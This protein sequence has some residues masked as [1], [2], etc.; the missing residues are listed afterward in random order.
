MKPLG[1]NEKMIEIEV[2]KGGETSGSSAAAS[3]AVSQ[4]RPTPPRTAVSANRKPSAVPSTPTAVARITLL[5]KAAWWLVSVMLDSNGS[6]VKPPSST[7]A[8]SSRC[9]IGNSTNNSS[10]IH[11]AAMAPSSAGSAATRR[12][13]ADCIRATTLLR[14][15]DFLHPTFDDALAVGAGVVVVDREDL[16]AFQNLGQRR[17]GFHVGTGRHEVDFVFG[18]FRLHGRAG[19][20][21]DQLLASL[22]TLRALDQGD[23]LGR[24]ADTLLGEADDDVIALGLGLERVD[25]E[26]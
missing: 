15:Q 25:D 6:S 2:V 18:E 13:E 7:K 19:C 16:G 10:R 5:T 1:P 20:E 26:E 22:G 8:R 3:S 24:A 17:I 4:C 12:H 23:R 9:A 11:T 14:R 21:V